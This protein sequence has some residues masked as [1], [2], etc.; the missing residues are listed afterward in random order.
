MRLLKFATCTAILLAMVSTTVA[1]PQDTKPAQAAAEAFVKAIVAKDFDAYKAL[2][3]AKLQAGHAKNPKN[4]M[5]TRWWTAVQKEVTQNHAKFVYKKVQSNLPGSVTLD[6]TRTMDSGSAV[7]H[8]GV[9]LE[10]G[11]WPVDSAGSM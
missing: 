1:A 2:C 3:T 11:K 9:R 6:Y 4:C 5:I 10:G 8:I 7:V